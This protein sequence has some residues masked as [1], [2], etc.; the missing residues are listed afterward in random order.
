M[1]KNNVSQQHESTTNNKKNH[2]KTKQNHEM[3]EVLASLL[4]KILTLKKTFA[5]LSDNYC[6]GTLNLN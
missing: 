2:Y 6:L 3:H 1:C 4:Y 5:S